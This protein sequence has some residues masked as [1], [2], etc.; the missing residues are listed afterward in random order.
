M[1]PMK[2]E[3]VTE[4]D[5]ELLNEIIKQEFPYTT[6]TAEKITSKIFDPAYFILKAHQK[7]VFCGFSEME[8]LGEE[9]R[10]NAVF[11]EEAWR[12]QKIAIKMLHRLIHECK[13]KR[14]HRLF[15]LVKEDNYPA[16]SLYT[17]VGFNFEKMHEKELDGSKVEVWNYHIN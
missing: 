8:Y 9:A 17:N 13:R 1:I 3:R 6:Y 11:V 10:V 7:N 5:A 16:K 12:G 14:I 4:E 15:L 2:L